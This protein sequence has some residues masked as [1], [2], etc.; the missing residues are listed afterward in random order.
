MVDK[1]P[2]D[3]GSCLFA[4]CVLHSTSLPSSIRSVLVGLLS[5]VLAL[6]CAHGS[7]LLSRKALSP[8]TGIASASIGMESHRG[9]PG[10]PNTARAIHDLI[11]KIGL[12]RVHLGRCAWREWRFQWTGS[13]AFAEQSHQGVERTTVTGRC[14][15]DPQPMRAIHRVRGVARDRAPGGLDGLF[16]EE[17][18]G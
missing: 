5:H 7:R 15:E 14:L 6:T 2:I 16:N 18:V 8:D 3:S 12:F 17:D 10:R 11:R 13:S 4:P 9:S 1:Q